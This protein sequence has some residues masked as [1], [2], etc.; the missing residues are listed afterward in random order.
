LYKVVKV[1]CSGMCELSLVSVCECLLCK[2]GVHQM[3]LYHLMVVQLFV[4][5]GQS[6][7][8]Y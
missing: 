1:A 4:R 7:K 2:A 3:L 8:H 6:D 5:V